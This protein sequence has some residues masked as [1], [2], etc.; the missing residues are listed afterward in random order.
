[1]AHLKSKPTSDQMRKA[2][3]C[4]FRAKR[5]KKPRAGASLNALEGYVARYN[6][7]VGKVH[8]A[9]K[10]H[11]NQEKAKTR[12]DKLKEQIARH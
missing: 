5:P 10:R 7:W 11:D 3:R 4:G 1:M 2:R 9:C 8:D 12:R 6:N